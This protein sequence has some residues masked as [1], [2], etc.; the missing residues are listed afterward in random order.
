MHLGTPMVT[1]ETEHGV[2]NASAQTS[3]FK[4]SQGV[5]SSFRPILRRHSLNSAMENAGVAPEVW[6][7]LTG[8]ASLEINNI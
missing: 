2:R 1:F 4:C 6:Q 7:P 3:A 5:F 8:Q